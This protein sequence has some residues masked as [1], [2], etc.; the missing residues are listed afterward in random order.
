M[1]DSLQPPVPP[2]PGGQTPGY[3]TTH[4]IP[5]PHTHHRTENNKMKEWGVENQA[6]L[7]KYTVLQSNVLACT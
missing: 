6:E 3:R 4:H 7:G 1:L 2:A 5:L